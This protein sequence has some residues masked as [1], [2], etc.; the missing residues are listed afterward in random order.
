MIPK[1]REFKRSLRG[2]L[3]DDWSYASHYVDSAIKVA[4]SIM[5]SWRR[6]YLKGR[7]GRNKPVVR[8]RFIRVKETL[9]RNGKIRMTIKPRELYL[10]FDLSRA[11]FKRRVEGWNL[12]ELILKRDEL[13]IAFRK[14][15][16]EVKPSIRIGWDLNKLSLDRF[17]PKLGWIKIGLRGLYHIHRVHELKI[18]RAQSKASKK[19]SLK[20]IVSKHGERERNRA[21]DFIHKLTTQLT[22]VFPNAEHGFED[23]EKQ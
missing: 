12:G 4:Y 2:V 20:P 21:R 15:V 1:S 18:K 14:E 6:N 22:R 10:E 8:R 7:R 11:W 5:S 16:R 23:L 9:Y 17:S 3:L 19:P 13:I